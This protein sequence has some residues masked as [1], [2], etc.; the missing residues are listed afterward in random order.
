MKKV[1]P[2]LLAAVAVIPVAG[3]TYF[4]RAQLT[5]HHVFA[6]EII[7][8]LSTSSAPSSSAGSASSVPQEFQK[9]IVSL[10]NQERA[11]KGL[12]PVKE[13]AML[14]RAAQLHAEDMLKKNYFSH[15]SK[16]GRSPTARMQAAGYKAPVCNCTIQTAYGENIARGQTSPADAMNAWMHSPVHRANIL[17]PSFK[18]IGVGMAGG[19]WVQTF[20]LLSVQK[21]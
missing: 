15:T 10:V 11:K 16:D 19:F 7:V 8:P 2:L 20:G 1:L 13:N 17:Y 18:E 21:R 4:L 12:Q 3:A 6:P 14:D 5:P 9:T